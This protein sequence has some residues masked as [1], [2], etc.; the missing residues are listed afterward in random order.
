MPTAEELRAHLE[1]YGSRPDIEHI[2]TVYQVNLAK[3]PKA[4]AWKVDDTGKLVR[5]RAAEAKASRPKPKRRRT[6]DALRA[7][8]AALHLT[9]LMPR[10][11]S[12]RLNIGERRV[13]EILATT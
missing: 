11:I 8:I 1:R 6:S 12:K 3:S 9:G 4:V 13:R 7:E 5:D 10:A 2:A